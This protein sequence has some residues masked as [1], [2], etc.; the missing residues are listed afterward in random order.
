[1]SISKFYHVL[2]PALMIRPAS[3]VSP[4]NRHMLCQIQNFI[5]NSMKKLY[6]RKRALK[7]EAVPLAPGCPGFPGIP[8]SKIEVH[9]YC[10]EH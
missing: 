10:R 6:F 7:A 9:F 1:M 8:K 4:K 2:L 3:P 5:I